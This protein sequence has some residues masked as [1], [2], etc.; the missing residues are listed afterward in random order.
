MNN[1]V[2]LKANLDLV[3]EDRIGKEYLLQAGKEP[4]ARG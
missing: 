2:K 4:I 3:K 1:F